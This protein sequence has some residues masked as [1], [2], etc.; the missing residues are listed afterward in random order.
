MREILVGIVITVAF[1]LAFNYFQGKK[2]SKAILK[3]SSSL[4]QEQLKNVSKLIVTEGHYSKVY[5]YKNSKAL[6]ANLY[7]VEKKALVIVNADVTIAYDLSKLEYVLDEENKE[8]I[9]TSIPNKEINVY[10]DFEY[11]DVQ[12]DFLNP[13]EAK[14]YNTINEDVRKRLMEKVEASNLISNAEN[15]LISE[16]AKFYILTNSLGWTLKYNQEIIKEV[17]QFEELQKFKK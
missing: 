13:F 2:E 12:A 5:T 4:I 8:L 17:D 10:P 1:M 16:L 7:N 14:D 6:F 15:R 9:I 11:Y 3:E